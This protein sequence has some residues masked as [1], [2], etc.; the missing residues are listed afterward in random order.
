MLKSVETISYEDIR[1]SAEFLMPEIFVK[2]FLFDETSLLISMLKDSKESFHDLP[3]DKKLAF[4]FQNE[5]FL[6]LKKL[7]YAIFAIPTSNAAV[8]RI[9][10]LCKKQ[11]TDDRNC[12][13]IET[14]KSFVHIKF[15]YSLTC[16]EMY[17]YLLINDN[18]L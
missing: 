13:K 17:D 6:D 7:V 9:F 15:N 16:S 12:L 18:L 1:K 14:V 5:S 3:V 11:W 8:E 2:D 10:S 4:L